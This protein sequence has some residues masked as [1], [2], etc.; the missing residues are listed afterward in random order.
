I[1]IYKDENNY[2]KSIVLKDTDSLRLKDIFHIINSTNNEKI[3]FA[4]VV[5]F[6]EGITDRLVFQR[7][8]EEKT[9]QNDL[10][11]IVEIIEIK[12]KND[13]N[14]MLVFL[15]ALRILNICISDIY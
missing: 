4:D 1:R 8:L 5:I 3:F 9:A 6:V 11:K 12:G 2:S 7:I 14:D 15:D 13:F 10:K